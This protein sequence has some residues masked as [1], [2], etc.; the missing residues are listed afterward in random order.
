MEIRIIEFACGGGSRGEV[1]RGGK[2][3]DVGFNV[4]QVFGGFGCFNTP[5]LSHVKYGFCAFMPEKGL[6]IRALVSGEEEEEN[7]IG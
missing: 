4:V 6:G 5:H 3:S 2:K 7:G 1:D